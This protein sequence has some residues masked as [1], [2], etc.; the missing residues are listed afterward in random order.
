MSYISMQEYLG[1]HKLGILMQVAERIDT[2]AHV[3]MRSVNVAWIMFKGSTFLQR[4][5][6]LQIFLK[7]A[8][9]FHQT[10]GV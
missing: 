5:L 10:P 3:V 4:M 6:H 7:S 8:A 2:D 9:V 1:D